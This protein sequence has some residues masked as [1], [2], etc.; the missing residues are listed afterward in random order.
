MSRLLLCLC[1]VLLLP[2]CIRGLIY[3]HTI[4][5]LSVNFDKT[6]V[7]AAKGGGAKGDVKH[8][9]YYVDFMWNTNA[10]GEIA[11]E[12]GIEEVYYADLEILRVAGVWAQ[13]HVNIYGR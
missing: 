7:A 5:P 11:K 12:N 2:G 10:I 8:F 1:L 9:R 4:E 13:Y 3:Q 6:P